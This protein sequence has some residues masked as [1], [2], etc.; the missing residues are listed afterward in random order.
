MK[1]EKSQ[2]LIKSDQLSGEISALLT[3]LTEIKASIGD[4]CC[5]DDVTIKLSDCCDK[6]CYISSYLDSLN[7]SLRYTNERLD[8]LSTSLWNHISTGHIPAITSPSQMQGALEALGISED[9]SVNKRVIYATSK[10]GK[11]LDAIIDYK[12]D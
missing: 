11:S 10:N 7:Y 5:S 6:V 2:S 8:Y 9:Y 1:I 4:P 3:K 12:K